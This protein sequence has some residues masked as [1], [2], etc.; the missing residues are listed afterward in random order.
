MF[1]LFYSISGFPAKNIA[2][3]SNFPIS[4]IGKNFLH[5]KVYRNKFEVGSLIKEKCMNVKYYRAFCP[6]DT[7]YTIVEDTPRLVEN[8]M[9][10]FN[11][12]PKNVR[13]EQQILSK[14]NYDNLGGDRHYLVLSGTCP[15]DM[16]IK[17]IIILFIIL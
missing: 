8:F 11:N 9:A 15:D 12:L 10:T 2:N 14:L 7:V 6:T 13:G 3:A 5:I 1:P 17:V 16:E 4:W